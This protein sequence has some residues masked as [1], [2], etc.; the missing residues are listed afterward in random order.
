[1]D[2]SAS[3]YRSFEFRMEESEKSENGLAACQFLSHFYNFTDFPCRCTYLLAQRGEKDD[4][5]EEKGRNTY[6]LGRKK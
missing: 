2:L 3:Y 5:G 6:T 4:D 1:M